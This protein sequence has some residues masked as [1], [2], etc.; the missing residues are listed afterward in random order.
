[1]G[2]DGVGLGSDAAEQILPRSRKKDRMIIQFD[3]TTDHPWS[4]G[5]LFSVLYS[6][7]GSQ[8]VFL[9]M[10]DGWLEGPSGDPVFPAIGMVESDGREIGIAITM[11]TLV[12]RYSY[13]DWKMIST[14][15]TVPYQAAPEFVVQADTSLLENF[16]APPLDTRITL[17][18][19]W[20]T[21]GPA[22]AD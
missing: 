19:L 3:T 21:G 11:T 9:G 16:L 8:C 13:D 4:P 2:N 12:G 17:E 22:V 5:P 14:F 18:P 10:D 7:A 20:L 15:V 1:M 6:L